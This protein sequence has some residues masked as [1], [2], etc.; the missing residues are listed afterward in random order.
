MF[1]NDWLKAASVYYWG[2]VD[3]R[4][5]EPMQWT[6]LLDKNG[7]EIYEGDIIRIEHCECVGQSTDGSEEEWI[8][9]EGEVFF[10]DA[11]FVF[12]GHSAGSLPLYAYKDDL[13]V[14]GNIY[15]NEDLLKL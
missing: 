12:E 10:E 5:I 6:G 2:L 11:M 9:C 14:I 13:E 15:E 4:T 1:N 3:S 7:K 8:S